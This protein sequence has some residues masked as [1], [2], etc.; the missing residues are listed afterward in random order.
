MILA[1]KTALWEIHT[2]GS[3][4][5]WEQYPVCVNQQTHPIAA[6]GGS[7]ELRF[8]TTRFQPSNDPTERTTDSHCSPG[9]VT[10]G[11]ATNR[12]R[13]G[14]FSQFVALPN[15]LILVMLWSEDTPITCVVTW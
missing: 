8:G 2:H 6:P 3:A 7:I 10:L 11:K 9:H 14:A 13:L 4:C 15:S 12:K 5:Y 1:C